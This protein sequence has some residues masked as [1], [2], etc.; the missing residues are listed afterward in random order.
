MLSRHETYDADDEQES[1]TEEAD[2][3]AAGLGIRGD[4][5]GNN[6]ECRSG[7]SAPCGPKM[8]D[9]LELVREAVAMARGEHMSA[10][11]K[12]QLMTLDRDSLGIDVSDPDFTPPEKAK[13]KIKGVYE[14]KNDGDGHI[15]T[16]KARG[17]VKKQKRGRRG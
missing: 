13:I 3:E 10:E 17:W 5:N 8:D 15:V 14:R 16:E 9:P 2:A 4:R 1:E 6:D 11:Q 7:P 12:A